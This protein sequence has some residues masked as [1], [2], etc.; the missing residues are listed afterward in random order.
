MR[1]AKVT[2]QNCS[3]FQCTE[4]S[5]DKQKHLTS[6]LVLLL[7]VSL[8][9]QCFN[10]AIYFQNMVNHHTKMNYPVI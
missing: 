7:C 9:C 3:H 6:V 4:L 2:L 10:Y 5:M 1:V 8:Q